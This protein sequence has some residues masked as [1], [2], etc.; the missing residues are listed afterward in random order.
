MPVSSQAGKQDSAEELELDLRRRNEQIC[1]L[2]KSLSDADSD[3]QGGD[4]SR[5]SGLHSI[6][7]ARCGLKFMFKEVSVALTASCLLLLK[8][9]LVRAIFFFFCF[10]LP[11][12]LLVVL[13]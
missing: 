9:Q 11:L 2:Q 7:E 10:Q 1:S 6:L 5:W 12:P 4:K 8:L 3:E 13:S